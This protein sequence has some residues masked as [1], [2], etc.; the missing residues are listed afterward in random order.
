[1]S[2]SPLRKILIAVGLLGLALMAL[3]FLALYRLGLLSVIFQQNPGR[4]DRPQFEAIVAQVRQAG[5][6]PG[7][8]Q[9]FFLTDFSDPKSLRPLSE[10]EAM[11]LFSGK[12]AGHVWAQLSPQGSLKVVIETRDLGH[13]GEYGFAYSDTALSPTPMDGGGNWYQVEV[14]G[15]LNIVEPRMK[16]DE[17]WWKV[18]NNLN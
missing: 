11:K 7:T 4:F 12:G 3:V 10:G 15:Y 13:A 2:G 8:E 14:P 18:L 17:H 1:M 9:Q 16:I 6:K 5:M